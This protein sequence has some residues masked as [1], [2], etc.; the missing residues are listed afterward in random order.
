MTAE[1]P[2]DISK[3]VADRQTASV[4]RA[5]RLKVLPYHVLRRLTIGTKIGLGYALVL[6]MA[7]FGSLA[8]LAVGNRIRSQVAAQQELYSQQEKL[9]SDLQMA[10]L[11]IRSREQQLIRLIHNPR[12]FQF[13]Y[14]SIKLRIDRARLLMADFEEFAT[15]NP[16]SVQDSDTTTLAQLLQN[17]RAVDQYLSQIEALLT[18]AYTLDDD[19]DLVNVRLRE[20]QL[21]EAFY[22]S[23]TVLK[24]DEFSQ[25]LSRVRTSMQILEDQA[26]QDLEAAELLRLHIVLGSAIVSIALSIFMA[27]Y[28]SRA[29]AYPLI[30]TTRVARQVTSD[31]N[32]DLQAP[33]TTQDEVGVLADSL[34]RLIQRVKHLLQEQQAAAEAQQQLQRQ[35][36]IQSEKMSSLGRMMAGVAHEIN[37]PVNFLYGNLDHA[38]HYVADLLDLLRLYKAAMPNPTMAIQTKTHEMDLDFLEEDLPKLLQS[39]KLG[40]DRTRQIVLSLKNFARMD[41]A[42]PHSVDLAAC[43][44]STLLILNNR[45]KQKVT[46]VR[47][48]NSVPAIQG[49]SGLLYQVFMNLLSNAV[50]ALD[51]SQ[52]CSTTPAK[53]ADA[54]LPPCN[55][56]IEITLKHDTNWVT[57][58]IADNGCGIPTEKMDRIFEAFYT[59]KP[60]GIGT[61]LGLSISREIIEDNHKGKI[62]CRST[63]GEG[64]EFR[65]QLPNVSSG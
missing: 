20:Q 37:N 38:N 21:F 54:H 65:I 57:V 6:G 25:R 51:E 18:Q 2:S 33:V 45:I 8:G 62:T 47:N 53:L 17:R 34:N 49:Y 7:T 50:D 42:E 31:A 10:L 15:R 59:T 12:Q 24:L 28:I 32:F 43:L 35:Q 30:A 36:M 5:S 19:S 41:D 22:Q 60:V 11:E 27:I 13:E 39:M 26:L 61:G 58:S 56:K 23:P 55:A 9:T 1:L 52:A 63:P 46:I 64:T 3:V 4:D 48:Y 44:D 40:A 29:I 16:A 14:S